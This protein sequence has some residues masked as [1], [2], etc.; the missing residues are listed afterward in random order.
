ML[1]EKKDKDALHW[2]SREPAKKTPKGKIDQKKL[3]RKKDSTKGEIE[4][5]DRRI[6]RAEGG[7]S[8]PYQF[9]KKGGPEKEGTPIEGGLWRG[10]RT[11]SGATQPKQ[12]GPFQRVKEIFKNGAK[13]RQRSPV[14]Q[15]KED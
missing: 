5:P 1:K 11:P 9:E 4:I 15:Q 7:E 14:W 3:R 2:T 8:F 10:G 13:N 6:A 12:V